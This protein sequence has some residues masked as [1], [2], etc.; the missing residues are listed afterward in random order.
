VENP[1]ESVEKQRW[2]W[3]NQR[4]SAPCGAGEAAVRGQQKGKPLDMGA[5]SGGGQAVFHSQARACFDCA[6][7]VV[8]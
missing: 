7:S 5:R 2:L 8:V 1:G 3:I 6:A 4:F